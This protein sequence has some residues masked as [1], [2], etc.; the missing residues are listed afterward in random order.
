MLRHLRLVGLSA[1]VLGVAFAGSL[2]GQLEAQAQVTASN[3]PIASLHFR[4]IGPATMSGRISDFAV[5]EKNPAIGR[6]EGDE[7]D[8]GHSLGRSATLRPLACQRSCARHGR[9]RLAAWR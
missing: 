3:D 5:Y 7:F 6:F 9:V 4:S 8:R 2:R 1:L